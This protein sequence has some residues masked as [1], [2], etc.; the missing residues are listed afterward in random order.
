MNQSKEDM[1]RKFITNKEIRLKK[2][3]INVLNSIEEGT[4][5]QDL[6]EIFKDEVDIINNNL[7]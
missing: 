7:M 6:Y 1:R 4:V 2:Q 3:Y 5:K